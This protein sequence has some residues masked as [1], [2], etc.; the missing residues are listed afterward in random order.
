MAEKLEI[1]LETAN[2]PGAEEDEED[3]EVVE[4]SEDGEVVEE[5]GPAI[6]NENIF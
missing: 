3:E 4:I 6:E 1:F 2:I 5:E